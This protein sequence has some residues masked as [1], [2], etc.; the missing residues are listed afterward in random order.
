MSSTVK[1]ISVIHLTPKTESHGL[2]PNVSSIAGRLHQDRDAS[3]STMAEILLRPCT[4]L[5]SGEATG[6]YRAPPI[7]SETPKKPRNN[8]PLLNAKITEGSETRIATPAAVAHTVEKVR[9]HFGSTT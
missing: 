5:V 1:N 3:I 2:C 6:L 9:C 7:R 8:R 4:G